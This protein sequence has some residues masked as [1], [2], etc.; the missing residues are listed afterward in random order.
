[1]ILKRNMEQNKFILLSLMV[2][3]L[4]L[5]SVSALIISE[6]MYAPEE[7]ENYNE[8]IEI[9]N[10]E[11]SD[12][13]LNNWSLCGKELLEGYV[14]H[15]DGSLNSEEGL[16]LS[17]GEYAII[18][19]GGS[20]TEIYSNFNIDSSSLALH[21]D[22][23]SLCSGLSNSGDEISLEDGTGNIVDNFDYEPNLGALDNGNSLQFENNWFNSGSRKIV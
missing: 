11:N 6:V 4:T 2:F 9:Y 1:M 14:A 19:D 18:S 17:S 20:G 10:D 7:N 12:V 22:A 8:W 15:S 23:S 5:Q 3:F 16:I 21:V 13:D